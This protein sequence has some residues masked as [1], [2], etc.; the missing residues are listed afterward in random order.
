MSEIEKIK[1]ENYQRMRR[2]ILKELQ[3]EFL[4]GLSKKFHPEHIE[5]IMDIFEEAKDRV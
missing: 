5:T 3:E 1:E 4:L 2:A